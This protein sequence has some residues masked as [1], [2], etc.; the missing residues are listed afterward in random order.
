MAALYQA[1]FLFPS[2]PPPPPICGERKGKSWKRIPLEGDWSA[3][4]GG[5]VSVGRDVRLLEFWK[6]F[7]S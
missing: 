1:W 2:P 4:E 5:D 7:I 3:R 6:L